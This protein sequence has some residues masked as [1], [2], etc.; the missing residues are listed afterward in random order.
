MPDTDIGAVI[1]EPIVVPASPIKQVL[2]LVVRYVLMGVAGTLASHGV[3]GKSLA[4][5]IVKDTTVQAIVGVVFGIGLIAWGALKTGKNVKVMHALEA[6]LPDELAH[7][8]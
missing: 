8:G 3:L 2:A 7:R 6:L 1:D 5:L 4:D